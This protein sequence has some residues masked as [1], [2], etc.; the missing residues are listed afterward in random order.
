MDKQPQ[1][2][3]EYINDPD[4]LA[5]GF[6]YDYVYDPDG[7]ASPNTLNL[8]KACYILRYWQGVFYFW[9]KGVY[10][11]VSKDE[12]RIELKKY[13][14]DLNFDRID[15]WKGLQVKITSH[16]VKD[17]LLCISGMKGVHIP[18][19]RGL[20]SWPDGREKHLQTIC[21]N[22]GLLQFTETKAELTPHTPE[23][24]TTVKLS[25]DYDKNADY[26]AWDTFIDDVMEGDVERR[27]LL[28]QWA[29]YLLM[30]GLKE[31]KFLLASGEGGNGKG[32]F[33]G[34]LERMIGEEN[35]SHVALS[36]FDN[37]YVLVTTVGKVANISNEAGSTIEALG[38]TVLK[39]Y[40]NGEPLTLNR[41]YLPPIEFR[42][43]AKVMIATNDLPR[44][45]DKTTAIWRRLIYVPF[46]KT[47]TEETRNINLIDELSENLSGVFNWAMEGV[48]MLKD[49]G[50]F[51]EPLV[52]RNAVEEYKRS[53]DP[54]RTF[55]QDN[56]QTEPEGSIPCAVVYDSYKIWCANN[57]FKAGSSATFG[58]AVKRVLNV[59]KGRGGV[60]DN[61]VYVYCG[62]KVK[63]NAEISNVLFQAENNDY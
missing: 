26:S 57:G 55:L 61:R 9:E 39:S 48:K 63:E 41:K 53:V 33:F 8:D 13:V 14:H 37:D 3:K 32:V 1:Y 59:S 19:N 34:V 15:V 35:C 27:V 12:M 56:Y 4:R 29:G 62:I 21:F 49:T 52:C 25:Y 42:A 11:E 24:F 2:T 22:N 20:N 36:S 5:E 7:E 28:Q 30:T 31:Q 50:G 45:R 44:F 58:K 16:L 43:T 51:V 18:E 47:Y 38:E 46:R 23:Y 40:T 54:A 10:R 60:Q 6:L 17:I